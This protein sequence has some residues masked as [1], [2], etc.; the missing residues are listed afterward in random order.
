MTEHHSCSVKNILHRRETSLLRSKHTHVH[1]MP[2]ATRMKEQVAGQV[3]VIYIPS[4]IVQEGW[5]PR[6]PPVDLAM[7]KVAEPVR[8]SGVIILYVPAPGQDHVGKGCQRFTVYGRPVAVFG[9]GTVRC[10]SRWVFIN[11][12]NRIFILIK[13]QI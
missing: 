3:L 12:G 7:G 10:I 4:I 11:H 1:G 2:P 9:T 5:L 6:P 8:M 13:G